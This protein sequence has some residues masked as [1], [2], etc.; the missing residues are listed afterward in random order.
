MTTTAPHYVPAMAEADD[1]DL[2]PLPDRAILRA[3]HR[4]GDHYLSVYGCDYCIRRAERD[5]RS[6]QRWQQRPATV[7]ANVANAARW[8][9]DMEAAMRDAPAWLDED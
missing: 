6:Y 4:D 7:M 1:L 9:Q 2:V 8:Q 5:R 3:E